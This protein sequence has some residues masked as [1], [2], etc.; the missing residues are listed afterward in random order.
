LQVVLTPVL[1]APQSHISN[2]PHLLYTTAPCCTLHA[3][4]QVHVVRTHAQHQHPMPSS[5]PAP[6]K[7]PPPS[8]LPQQH[9]QT[10][11]TSS[12]YSSC[13]QYWPTRLIFRSVPNQSWSSSS[14]RS[15][16]SGDDSSR[17][18]SNTAA[19]QCFLLSC[20]VGRRKRIHITQRSRCI[21]VVL[22]GHCRWVREWVGGWGGWV[23]ARSTKACSEGGGGTQNLTQ[24]LLHLPL[25]LTQLLSS[26]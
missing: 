14:S 1:D 18:R 8:P 22:S 4:K 25:L 9:L 11:L 10:P 2:S 6:P 7:G 12:T 23:D 26:R 19:Q 21:L 16:S 20:T 17:S 5:S 15:S 3:S 13:V 24:L